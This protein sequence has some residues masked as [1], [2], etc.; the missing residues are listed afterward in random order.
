MSHVTR[1]QF[2][3]TTAATVGAMGLTRTGL[4]QRPFS[5]VRGANDDIRVAVVGIGSSVKIGGKGKQEIRDFLKIP[6]VRVVALCDPD[7]NHL[8][9]EAKKFKARNTP[10]DTYTDVRKLLEDPNID[11]VN[12]VTPNHW[13]ALITVWACQAGKDVFVQKPASHNIF[14]GRKMVEAA[15]KYNRVVQ[16]ASGPR[17]RTGIGEAFDHVRQGHLGKILYAHGINYKPRTSIGKVSKPT[18]V[19]ATLDYDLW[20]GP[21]PVKPVMRE[22]L[23]YDWHW[24]WAY[25]NGDLGNMG[26]HYMDAARWALGQDRLPERVL[27]VG[28]RFGYDDDGETANTH[29]GF[30]DYKPAPL[31]FEVRGLPRDKSLQ[32]SGWNSKAMDKYKDQS[33]GVVVHCEHGYI[34]KNKAYDNDGNLIK[35]FEPTHDDLKVNFIKAVRSRKAEDLRTDILQGHLSASL[36]HMMNIS[37]RIGKEKPVEQVREVVQGQR[38]F[39]DAFERMLTHLEVNG[40][41]VKK[42]PLTLGPL[43]NMNSKTERFKGAFARRANKLARGTYR[44]PFVVPEVV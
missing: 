38:D 41:D 10:A 21:A 20:S 24:D 23:H 12:V 36:V 44:E 1:R 35:T 19:P 2:L 17:N 13:H 32:A 43:L 5:R 39:S 15:E 40:I 30:F 31:I 29:I 27:S 25:G 6:G 9:G 4:G 14:E 18:A 42:T 16:S 34:S 33:I 3:K 22:C 26:I 8:Q 7:Q 11:A 28:G 37:H